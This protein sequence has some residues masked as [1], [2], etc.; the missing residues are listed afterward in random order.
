MKKV[1]TC[2]TKIKVYIFLMMMPNGRNPSNIKTY[3]L[4]GTSFNLHLTMMNYHFIDKK[5]IIYY[6]ELAESSIY[7]PLL[8]FKN[9]EVL[10][11]VLRDLKI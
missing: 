2:I 1:Q 5:K 9:A 4:I 7:S 6:L 11:E 8:I 10:R 3:C